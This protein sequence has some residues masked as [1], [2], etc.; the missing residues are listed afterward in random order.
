MSDG[1]HSWFKR[2]NT[3]KKLAVT[4][5]DDDDHDDDD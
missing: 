5:Y 1:D 2:R 4:G 3:G